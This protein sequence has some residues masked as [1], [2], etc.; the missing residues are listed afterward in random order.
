MLIYKYNFYFQVDSES[1]GSKQSKTKSL[2]CYVSDYTHFIEHGVGVVYLGQTNT[3]G[4]GLQMQCCLGSDWSEV[5]FFITASM[6]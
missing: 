1:A 6:V 3:T 2:L 5:T 4:Q